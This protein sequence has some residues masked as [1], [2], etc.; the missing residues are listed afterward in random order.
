[1]ILAF[2]QKRVHLLNVPVYAT[3]AIPLL[4]AVSAVVS[5]ATKA[6][7]PSASARSSATSY[8]CGPVCSPDLVPKSTLVALGSLLVGAGVTHMGTL[9]HCAQI[10]SR[11][12][13]IV[14]AL[15]EMVVTSG[16][17]LQS[18]PRFRLHTGGGWGSPVAWGSPRLHHTQD[19]PKALGL[20][21]LEV[22]PALILG[23]HSFVGLPFTNILL[24]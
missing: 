4:L 8:F 23:L 3:T 18:S 19:K 21:N 24:S 20:D 5:V 11:Y 9:I 14:I 16:C 2:L 22:I 17:C 13:A 6:Y 12:K 15:G 10:R 7:F 1:M